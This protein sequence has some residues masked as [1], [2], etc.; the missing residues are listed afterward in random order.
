MPR[1]PAHQEHARIKGLVISTVRVVY[2]DRAREFSVERLGL[3]TDDIHGEYRRLKD[4][5]VE[6]L[7][8]PQER[9]Y[10]TEAPFRDDSGN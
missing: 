10:G 2:R 5:G 7:Q 1:A 8:E 6:F 9:P 3:S 4:R